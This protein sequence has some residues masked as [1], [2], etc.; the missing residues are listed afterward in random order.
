VIDGLEHDPPTILA[1]KFY[2]TAKN[3]TFTRHIFDPSAPIVSDTTMNRLTADEQTALRGAAAEGVKYQRLQAAAAA[4]KALD[5]LKQNGLQT[6]D[7]DRPALANEVKP[8]WKSF[9]DQHPD[10]KPVLQAILTATNQ[11]L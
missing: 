5:Q 1:F 7:I 11:S 9:G 8:L 3:Y 6:H 10:A 2:E 4:A